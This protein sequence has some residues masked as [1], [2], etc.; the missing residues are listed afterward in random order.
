MRVA[1][2][3]FK[4]ELAGILTQ[5]DDGAFIFIYKE[6]WMGDHTKP[7]ISPTLPKSKRRFQSK[8]LFPF[9]YQLL[10]EGTNK[11]AVTQ[12]F[13]IDPSD[14]FGILLRVAGTDTIGAVTLK[15]FEN[16]E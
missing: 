14:D 13:N 6:E 1:E 16:G 9:F 8:E 4:N 5:K 15:K 10:P 12:R 2:V 11:K 3:L 7:S